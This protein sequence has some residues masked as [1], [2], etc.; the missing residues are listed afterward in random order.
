[1]YS[2][3]CKNR[4]HLDWNLII[5]VCCFELRIWLASF[6]AFLGFLFD[7]FWLRF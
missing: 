6:V 7:W 4:A 2:G 3:V 5:A 1:L